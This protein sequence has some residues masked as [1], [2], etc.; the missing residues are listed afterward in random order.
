[1]N[2]A[3]EQIRKMGTYNTPS[4]ERAIYGGLLLDFNERL[5]PL[6]KGVINAIK[7]IDPKALLRYPSYGTLQKSIASY[8][9]VE[10]ENILIT[11]G[12]DIGME[13]IFRTFISPGDVCVIPSP[14]FSMF[15]QFTE[16]LGASI[17]KPSYEPSGNFPI[18]DVIKLLRTKPKLLI[19]CNPNNPTG[20]LLS[21]DEIEAILERAEKNTIIYID[22]A[23]VE[24]SGVSAVKLIKKYPNLFITR[25]FSKAFGLA[26]L[27][28]GYV[29]SRAENI[30][31]MIKVR[32]PYEINQIAI[33]AAGAS[34]DSLSNLKKYCNEV[35]KIAK[36]MVEKFFVA[37]KI[38]FISSK[39][40]FI[41]FKE[42]FAD[43]SDRLKKAGIL[44]RPQTAGYARVTIGTVIQMRKFIQTFNKLIS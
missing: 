40:N 6:P 32:G 31:E 37:K 14:S 35:M 10:G 44:I 43:F 20:T 17:L 4:E 38:K 42:P 13:L 25:T 34:L 3:L 5:A 33:V 11:N 27:R 41:Y 29:I 18:K 24:F 22:E 7:K 21:I 19:I 1:M 36:P 9:Q 26:A 8:A 28:I 16:V 30:N 15:Y 23:Y 39:A 2:L 12:S